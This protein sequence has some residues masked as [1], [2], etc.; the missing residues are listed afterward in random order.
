MGDALK[1]LAKPDLTQYACTV[2]TYL[3]S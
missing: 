2:L 3:S 1:A